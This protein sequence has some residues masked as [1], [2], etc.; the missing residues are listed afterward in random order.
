[1]ATLVLSAAGAAIGGPVGG[2][3]GSFVGRQIDRSFGAGTGTRLS[4]LRAPSSQYGDPIPRIL[5]QMRVAGV[6]LWASAPVAIATVSKSGTEQASSVSFA[7]G[8]S[9][10]FIE[11]VG[12]IWADGRLIRDGEGRQDVSFTLRLH[13]GD[14]DQLSDPLIASL[15][16]EE[17]APAFRGIAY[18]V[19]ENFDLSTFGNRLPLITVEVLAGGDPIIAEDIIRSELDVAGGTDDRPHKLDG[20]ALTG[21]DGAAAL[22][23]LFDALKPGLSYDGRQW[24]IGAALGQH[25]IDSH[26]WALENDR[27]SHFRMDGQSEAP[28][29]V[30]VRYFDPAID[31]LAGEKSARQPGVE[32]LRRIELPAA[33]SGE[34]A[35]ALAFERLQQAAQ[36]AKAYWLTL[37][38]S[39]AA[40]QVGDQ[41]RSNTSRDFV[42]GEKT[43]SAGQLKLRLR[44]TNELNTPNVV[45]IEGPINPRLLQRE[46]LTIA[47][48]ELPNP[49]LPNDLEIAIL[50]SGG[51]KPFRALPIVIKGAGTEVEMASARVA[52]PLGRL[53]RPLPSAS[54]SL[55]DLQSIIEVE[56]DQDPELMSCT[57]EALFAGAN[58][59]CV[60]GEF[61]QF[62]IAKPMG[63][64]KYELSRLIRRRFD[65]GNDAPHDVGSSAFLLDPASL[66]TFK[67]PREAVGTVF[68]AR[69][70][71]PD[72]AVAEASLVVAGS[73]ARPW[74]PT[75]LNVCETADGLELSWVRRCREGGVWLDNVDAP[76]GSS[77]EAYQVTL[78]D[79]LG[80]TI[81]AQSDN[82]H[83]VFSSSMLDQMTPRPWRLEVRQIGDFAA[84]NP[85]VHIID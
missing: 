31:Y 19:F 68:T 25:V 30:S 67:V 48:V 44:P 82:P 79:G 15:L 40:I 63:A 22:Q 77:R 53:C 16:G 55:L 85:L 23:P 41:V 3:V 62:A 12:R 36:E 65:S 29:K 6:V 43:L 17:N 69:V 52:A 47:L 76:L 58:L 4:D 32:R 81:E 64:A 33:M 83:S 38:L 39:Y 35:K 21:D 75:H 61:I 56:F 2:L 1:M 27:P 70:F 42:V 7:Y 59:L 66:V 24:G 9:S 11:D 10:G 73:A 26:L 50:V 18:L 13:H 46:H 71:G 72:N 74:A 8:L 14:E 5:R 54:G 28:T 80:M 57:D 60:N 49:S 34:R 37:P 51:H 84:G 45:D 20:F 78:R